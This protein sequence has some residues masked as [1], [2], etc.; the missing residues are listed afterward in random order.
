M[1]A[2]GSLLLLLE[3]RTVFLLRLGGLVVAVDWLRDVVVLL[4]LVIVS[5]LV[6]NV[7]HGSVMSA[8]MRAGESTERIPRA[9]SSRS[10]C[11][12]DARE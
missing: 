11:H 8:V 6:K 7:R 12:L 2:L 4:I 10:S 5:L 1:A 3:V 9:W